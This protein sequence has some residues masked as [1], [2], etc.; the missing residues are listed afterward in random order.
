MNTLA[1]LSRRAALTVARTQSQSSCVPRMIPRMLLSTSTAAAAPPQPFAVESPEGPSDL[2]R[3]DNLDWD[4]FAVDY[5]IMSGHNIK[6]KEDRAAAAMRGR[7]AAPQPFAVESP[8]GPSDLERAENLDW[9][10][11]AVD[12]EI[13]SGHNIKIKEGRADAAKTFAVESPDGTTDAEMMDTAQ[14]DE[15]AIERELKSGLASE[16]IRDRKEA[17]KVFAVES[18]EGPSDLE[19]ADNLDWDEF[20]VDYEIMSGH[21]IKIKE[22]RAAAAKVL[23]VDAPDG[24][25]DAELAD[26]AQWDEAVIDYAAEHEDLAEVH[27]IHKLEQDVRRETALDAERIW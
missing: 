3:A 8:E 1:I 22:G 17:A 7:T 4:E 15:Q 25:P 26:I 5:E 13:M 20:A 14:W 23:A 24:T 21:N 10:E 9:Y 27:R 16:I 11:F 2:E 6:I 19:R 12:Y 18:P